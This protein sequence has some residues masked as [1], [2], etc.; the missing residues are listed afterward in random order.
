ME[1]VQAQTLQLIRRLVG[2]W[3]GNGIAQFPTTPTFEYREELAFVANEVQAFVRYEQRTWR[4][5]E[6]GEYAPSH[7]E[8]GFWRVL[9]L[10]EIEMLN[11]Q[12][13]GRVE[14]ARGTLESLP[15]GFMVNL[16]STL[17]ANDARMDKTAR[18]FTLRGD[19]LE[20]KTRMSTT[21][22]PSLTLHTHATLT[23]GAE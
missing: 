14:V 8:I 7:W 20:Y 12:A 3:R 18:Q 15:D 17:V 4:K 19:R 11:S 21:A 1:P 23:R 16:S 5:L 13:G 10:G 9:P 22:V 2:N 6:T